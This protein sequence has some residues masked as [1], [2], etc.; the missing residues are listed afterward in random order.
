MQSIGDHPEL[1]LQSVVV[2]WVGL[3]V[4]VCMRVC[5]C[6][7][8]G[9]CVCVCVGGLLFI[10][11]Q[12]LVIWDLCCGVVTVLRMSVCWVVYVLGVGGGSVCVGV[13][14]VLGWCLYWE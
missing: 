8:V 12:M 14:S 10:L 3:C 9:V 7:W 2:P 11:V 6:G 1:Y 13:V 4:R 5:V